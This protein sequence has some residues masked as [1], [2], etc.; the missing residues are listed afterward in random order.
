M[1][2]DPV[3]A[4]AIGGAAFG[5]VTSTVAARG[6]NAA[7]RSAASS[8]RRAAGR[9]QAQ[10]LEAARLERQKR[11][12]EARRL[13][14]RVRASAAA[15]GVGFGGSVEALLEENARVASLDR[16]LIDRETENRIALVQSRAEA[17][18]SQLN[19]QTRSLFLDALTGSLSGAITGV[20]LGDLFTPA[21]TV[22]NAA[23]SGGATGSQQLAAAGLESLLL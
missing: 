14:G 7:A 1:G 22:A 10:T 9:E 12:S 19:T 2:A 13:E 5:G 16:A 3:T 6:Q 20:A 23:A 15:R 18:L 4:L 21:A 17:Q 11:A 8:V